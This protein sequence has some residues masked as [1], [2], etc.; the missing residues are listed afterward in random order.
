MCLNLSTVITGHRKLRAYL[1]RFKIIVDAMC[2]CETNPQSTDHVIWEW[3][4]L[5]KLRQ[6]LRNSIM[7]AGGSWP[8]SNTELANMYMNIF[9]KFVNAINLET[10]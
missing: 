2:P 4:L 7:K 9:Q 1:H 5:N 8:M 3:T 6:S 10:L